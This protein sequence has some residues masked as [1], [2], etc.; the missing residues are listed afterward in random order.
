LP[1]NWVIDLFLIF[2]L[3]SIREKKKTNFPGLFSVI[4]DLSRLEAIA[5]P[6]FGSEKRPSLMDVM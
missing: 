1:N 6:T 2:D 4:G 5:G 3:I